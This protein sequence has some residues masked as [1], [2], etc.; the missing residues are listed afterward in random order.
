M[1]ELGTDIPLFLRSKFAPSVMVNNVRLIFKSVQK[2]QN[3][4]FIRQINVAGH[5]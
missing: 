2:K 3:L 1:L 5:V 4:H